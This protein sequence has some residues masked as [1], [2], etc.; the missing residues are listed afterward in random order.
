MKK[1]T[2]IICIAN[3]KGGVAKTTTAVNLAASWASFGQKVLLIDMDGQANATRWLNLRNLVKTYKNKTLSQGLLN[4]KIKV[5]DLVFRTHDPHLDVLASDMSLT[6]IAREKIATPNSGLML[7]RLLD[8]SDLDYDITIIDTHPAL[9]LLF[10][11]AM[12]VAHYY[13]IP[14][15]PEIDPLEGCDYMFDDLEVIKEHN[16]TLH[17]LGFVVTDY[18]AK[19]KTHQVLLPEIQRYAK[20]IKHPV[21]GVIPHSGAV[22]SSANNCEA[23]IWRKDALPVTL[24]YKSLA[25][26]ILP[27]LRGARRGAPQS[28]PKTR[29]M[30]D[31]FTRSDLIESLP[32]D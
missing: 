15:K 19:I 2:S 16:G 24:A 27:E 18:D 29:M 3:Q 14:L 17:F 28:S 30:P 22:A 21:L 8:R 31:I 32:T 25:E 26:K 23:L 9:D 1:K 13:L 12:N 20:S 10:Q 6:R 5:D 7:E 11:N 4:S